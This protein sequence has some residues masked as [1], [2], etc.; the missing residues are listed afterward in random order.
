MSTNFPTSLDS[1]QDKV[2]NVST[3]LASSINN[4]QDAVAA[5]QTKVGRDGSPVNTTFD[6]RLGNDTADPFFNE[7]VRG[8]YFYQSTA[9]TGWSTSGLATNCVVGIKGGA[10]DW[11]TVG[12]TR[13]GSW[14]IENVNDDLHNHMWVSYDAAYGIPYHRTWSSDGSTTVGWAGYGAYAFN[15]AAYGAIAD[16]GDGLNKNA[17]FIPAA[18]H[19]T[20]NDTHDHS[21]DASWR[22]SAAVGILAVYVGS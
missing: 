9:P 18:D 8:M 1:Y 2:D 22:P 21:F 14:T 15:G 7:N 17:N 19:Y 13:S 5:L 6:Y 20:A 3:V 12:A 4:L 10:D 16:Y 11:N